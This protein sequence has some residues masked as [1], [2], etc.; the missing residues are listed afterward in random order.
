MSKEIIQVLDALCEKFGIAI[1]WSSDNIMPYLQ[2]VM[3]RFI[4]YETVI[5]GIWI[6]IGVISLILGI[7]LFTRKIPLYYQKVKASE[8]VPD[9]ENLFTVILVITGIISIALIIT[10][11]VLIIWSA[12][13]IAAIQTLPEKILLKELKK[14][15]K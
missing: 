7:Y 13:T 5:H 15:Y 2:D 1:D 11:I 14:L 9:E 6:I 3:S 8:N 12:L 10:G 4:R